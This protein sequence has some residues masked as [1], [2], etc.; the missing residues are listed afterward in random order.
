[1]KPEYV[2][3]CTAFMLGEDNADQ[4]LA[5]SPFMRKTVK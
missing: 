5:L 2:A 4:Y 1:M 3:D